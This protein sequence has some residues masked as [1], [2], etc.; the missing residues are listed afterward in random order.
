[1]ARIDRRA[2]GRISQ[3]LGPRG[4]INRDGSDD[5]ADGHGLNGGGFFSTAVAPGGKSL[6]ATSGISGSADS[7]LRGSVMRFNRAP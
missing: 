7:N 6:Y 3:P 2:D 4:C 1:V 5:C